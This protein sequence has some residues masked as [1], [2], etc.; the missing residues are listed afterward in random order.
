MQSCL[1]YLHVSSEHIPEN[2]VNSVS[3]NHDSMLCTQGIYS[4]PFKHMLYRCYRIPSMSIL[5]NIPM[6][7]G[8]IIALGIPG[9]TGNMVL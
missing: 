3:H 1:T 9:T 8:V 4:S 6:Y 2:S 5:Q 7:L